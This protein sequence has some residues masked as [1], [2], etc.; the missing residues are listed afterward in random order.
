M[1][2]TNEAVYQ[3][4]LVRWVGDREECEQIAV[5]MDKCKVGNVEAKVV[6]NDEKKD[7]YICSQND[8]KNKKWHKQ[9]IVSGLGEIY[10]GTLSLRFLFPYIK[11][12]VPLNTVNTVK[13][14]FS[15]PIT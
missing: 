4:E 13:Q 10:K 1:E 3:A 7:V 12:L 8:K 14:I 9:K 11:D 15:P 5:D 2:V 6:V